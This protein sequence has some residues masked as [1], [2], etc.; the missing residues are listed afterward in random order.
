MRKPLD[1]RGLR[2]LF[3]EL[4][5]S[6]PRTEDV[7]V[8]LTGGTTAVEQGWRDSTIDADLSA[9]SDKVFTDIPRIKEKL[10]LNVEFAK[11]TDFVPSLA[12]EGERHIFVDVVGK[13]SFYH[14]DPYG[15][16]F[17][18]IVR[19]FTHDYDDVRAMVRAGWVEPRELVR[20]VKALSE[21][22]FLKYPRLS[23]NAVLRAVED[24]QN[25]MAKRR[26]ARRSGA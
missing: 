1:R 14:F 19:G 20:M 22:D 24:F 6:A 10:N 8:Y 26:N 2:Q 25:D 5:A 16:A 3:K 15:Q 11:P 4:A 13:L 23:K 18:K 21:T 7:R 17:S 9:D 12:G